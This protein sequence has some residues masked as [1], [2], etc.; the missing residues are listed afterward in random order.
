MQIEKSK[1]VMFESYA[2][3]LMP[4]IRDLCDEWTLFLHEENLGHIENLRNF[5]FNI[6]CEK[7]EFKLHFVKSQR[8][9]YG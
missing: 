3:R 6:S 8:I 1:C 9:L 7:L 5:V 4:N 2:F